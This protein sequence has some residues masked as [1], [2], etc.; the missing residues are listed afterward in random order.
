MTTLSQFKP[1]APRPGVFWRGAAWMAGLSALFWFVPALN[2]LIGGLTGGFKVGS[3]RRAILAAL[4]AM[5]VGSLAVWI[6]MGPLRL[7][8]V[9][10]FNGLSPSLA[11]FFTA[12][13][14]LVGAALGGAS[15]TPER[16]YKPEPR[17]PRRREPLPRQPRPPAPPP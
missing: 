15:G 3:F 14:V 11:A 16:L 10:M 9:G 6:M 12:I 5:A 13:G 8:P 7:P 1:A 2:G 4:P 17:Q